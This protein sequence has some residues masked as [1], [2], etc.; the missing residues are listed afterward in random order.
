MHHSYYGFTLCKISVAASA[1][2]SKSKC[3]LRMESSPR[4]L[5]RLRKSFSTKMLVSAIYFLLGVRNPCAILPPPRETGRRVAGL[6]GCKEYGSIFLRLRVQFPFYSNRGR[7][8]QI[9]SL[10][11]PVVWCIC[12]IRRDRGSPGGE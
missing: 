9:I 6:S 4:A 8:L 11:R 10:G 2:L 5:G 1:V 3:H 7:K 12:G